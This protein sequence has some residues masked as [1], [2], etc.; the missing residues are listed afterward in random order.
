MVSTWFRDLAVRRKIAMVI[1]VLSLVMVVVLAFALR[2]VYAAKQR[3]EAMYHQDLISTGDL[4]TVRTAGLRSMTAL[5]RH[6]RA[7]SPAEAAQQEAIMSEVDV[8]F[9]E[10]WARYE[11]TLATPLAREAAP[12]YRELALQQ[13]QARQESMAA[14]KKGQ[15]E[16][17]KQIMRER[18]DPLEKDLGPVGGQLVKEGARH[19]AEALKSGDIAAQ[20]GIIIGIVLAAIGIALGALM[21]WGLVKGIDEPLRTFGEVMDKVAT[22]DLT[23]Q[24]TMARKD[25]F[26]R[27]AQG[28]DAMVNQLRHLMQ[29]IRQGVEGV[30]SGATQ[31][32]ASAEEMA[33]TSNEIA[34]SA[35]TQRNGSEAMVAAVGELS[36]SIEEV[37]RGAQSSLGRLEEAQE[38]TL[39]GD[40]SGQATHEAMQGITATAGQIAKA[41]SVIQEIAQQTNLLSL[42]A[43]IEAAKA[44]EHGKGFAVVAEE[45]RKL[46]E[47]SSVS[48]KEIA[49]YI[50][51]A[52][53]AIHNGSSTVATTVE[54]LKQIRSVLDDFAASTRQAAAATA[55]QAS[56]GNDVARQVEGN[57]QEAIAIASAITEMSATT[58]EVARTSADLHQLA[59]G[60]QVQIGRFSI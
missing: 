44:G 52:N 13:R 8:Q 56:A 19:A 47:R 2:E 23:V 37:N 9:D 39:K 40:R 30:A 18:S 27:L 50:E 28:L 34:R 57:A 11:K 12:K 54:I 49:R 45:V 59:E 25:E 3:A 14:S 16:L 17:A 58:T 1:G 60:L 26:G 10:A 41:V 42:N 7:A 22:G 38:A 20:R 15:M 53:Q 36:A 5:Y 33:T 4:T 43:A 32:S 6:W 46:A 29:G 55:E 31:L 21:G 35:E 51:E 48:A 24:V